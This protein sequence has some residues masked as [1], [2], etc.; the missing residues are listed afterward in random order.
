MS[1]KKIENLAK[2][3]LVI[4]LCDLPPPPKK[5]A[6]PKIP[7][8]FGHFDDTSDKSLYQIEKLSRKF[9]F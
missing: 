8:N 9:K 4:A 6:I 3:T 7:G 1:A 2:L 5:N